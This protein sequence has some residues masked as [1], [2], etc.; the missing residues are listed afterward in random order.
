MSLTMK[1]LI[2][3]GM[4]ALT[5]LIAAETPSTGCG[6]EPKLITSKA[7]STPLTITPSGT[8]RQYY[9]KLPENYNSSHPYRLIFTLHALGGN[10]QQVTVGT[11]GYLPWYGLPALINDTRGAIYIAP[12]GLRSGWWNTG[13]DDV[14][15]LKAVMDTV[16]ADLCI[17]QDL[18]FSTGF[19]HGAAMSYILAC[20]LGKVMRAVAVLS[21]NPSI[22]GAC[23]AGTAANEPVA[24]YTQHGT[25]DS[26]L[27]IAQARQM[28]DRYI[29]NNGC[30]SQTA[31]EPTQ[32]QKS[33]TTKYEGCKPGYPV[34]W[35]AFDGDHTPQPRD[36]G[37]SST[38]AAINTWD[39]FKQFS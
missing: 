37:V 10:A 23:P 16:E 22:S 18:R 30:A 7:A 24:Y 9:V 13:G 12:T 2:V 15:F 26:V 1:N 25:H 17:D 3:F 27:P 34:T 19:S 4:V 28:R 11:G 39:F 31:P 36:P 20:S 5:S 14:T 21:G 33:I 35:V 8:A 29:K 32:G 6:K 38:F